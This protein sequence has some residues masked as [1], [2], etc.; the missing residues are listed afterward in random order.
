MFIRKSIVGGLLLALMLGSLGCGY[1]QDVKDVWKG[2]R[3]F[4]YRN[5]SV[6]ASIDYDET[7]AMSEYRE[8]L[9]LSMVGIDIQLTNLEKVMNN[10]D[11]PPTNESVEALFAKFP[12]LSGFTGVKADGTI[13]GQVPSTPLKPLDFT[14]LLHEDAKQN[15]RAV[16]GHVQNT[17]MGPEV[18]LAAPLYDAHDFLGIVSVYFD[19]RELLQF[20][21]SPDE[22]VIVSPQ[23]VLWA[24][25]YNFASTPLAG[26][27][28]DSVVLQE[29]SGTVSNAN[30]EFYW[31]VRY[32][33]NLPIIFAVAVDGSF[34]ETTNDRTGPTDNTGFVE[35]APVVYEPLKT[36]EETTDETEDGTAT[37][38]DTAV[39]PSPIQ[40]DAS[41]SDTKTSEPAD[42]PAK[43]PAKTKP[44]PKAKPRP[45]HIYVPVIEPMPAPDPV[46]T[47]SP[48]YPDQPDEPE[49]TDATDSTSVDS[50]TDESD[51]TSSD[52]ADT[53][54]NNAAET[55]S[56]DTDSEAATS[57]EETSTETTST[58]SS[59]GDVSTP[60]TGSEQN[61]DDFER[62]SPFGPQ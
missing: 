4:F 29:S 42:V 9:A 55:T 19:M 35:A 8:Q 33:G 14:P 43:Q 39:T 27:A 46:V 10:A 59:E 45:S 3:S 5:V 18:F 60:E 11:K 44:K 22:L 6:P 31:S 24:G 7:G 23:A 49:N 53:D 52:T 54:T 61:N 20:S 1:N 48:I 30:G 62:P 15:L 32:F 16:R 28:W 57:T 17:P 26:I 47:P 51:T 21:E 50:S 25:K 2:T 12:W 36:N 34:G 38:G 56:N 37:T 58:D 40:P 41:S 13:L